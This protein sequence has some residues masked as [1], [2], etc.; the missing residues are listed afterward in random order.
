LHRR[1]TSDSTNTM[2]Q[3]NRSAEFFN[4]NSGGTKWENL[5]E[6]QKADL[7]SIGK[8]TPVKMKKC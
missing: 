6:R 3:R 7:R 2:N 8:A 1:F 4:A 5:N